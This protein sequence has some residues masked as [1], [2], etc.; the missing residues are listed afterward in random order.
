MRILNED[1][2]KSV[3]YMYKN[4]VRVCDIAKKLH[5]RAK[6]ISDTLKKNNITPKKARTNS[7]FLNEDY[8]D[9]INSPEKAYF[10]GLLFTD[11]SVGLDKGG[12]S[13]NIRLEIAE[14]DCCVLYM[15]RDELN[16]CNALSYS[17]RKG[18]NGTYT[19]SVRSEKLAKSLEKYNI[20]P[21]KTYLSDRLPSV[22]EEY[23]RPF[24]HGLIDGDGSVYF[25]RGIWHI[26]FCS[27]FE[28]ICREFETICSSL[29]SKDFHPKIQESN[30]V[31]R[32]TYN[33][34]WAKKLAKE[35]LTDNYGI[36]RKRLLAEQMFEDKV[37]EDIVYST[38]KDAV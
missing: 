33:G 2:E 4:G 22:P 24:V 26:N 20:V 9:E 28:S 32:I 19:L 6:T 23:I 37:A 1:E 12:R 10:I 15:L 36:A 13:P 25:S 21:N 27:H 31:Y 8:F 34:Q 5:C 30:G 17:K 7:W 3:L 18:R 38:S 16:I 29:I 14:Q 11:G 35:C